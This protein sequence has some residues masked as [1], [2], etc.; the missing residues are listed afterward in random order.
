MYHAI[1]NMF[2]WQVFNVPTILTF[3]GAA[4]FSLFGQSVAIS[5]NKLTI[6][7]NMLTVSDNKLTVSG[8]KLTV[9][10][11]KLTVSGNKRTC[12]YD[13]QIIICNTYAIP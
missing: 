13:L 11:N 4:A 1:T 5:G 2:S 6:S 7:G 8:N 9:S 10:D 3:T 12:V